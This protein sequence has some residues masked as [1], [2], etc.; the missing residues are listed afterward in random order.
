MGQKSVYWK[1]VYITRVD[2]MLGEYLQPNIIYTNKETEKNTYINSTIKNNNIKN[3]DLDIIE[4]F[5]TKP[6]LF[7]YLTCLFVEI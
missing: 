2:C 1:L 7:Q 4:K 5:N 6:S 3:S